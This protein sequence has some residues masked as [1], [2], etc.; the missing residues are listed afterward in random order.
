VAV[1]VQHPHIQDNIYRDIDILFNISAVLSLISQSLAFP[2]TK[3]NLKKALIDQLDFRIEERNLGRFNEFF[4]LHHN[5]HFPKV[6][7]EVTS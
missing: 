4:H 7:K 3:D 2:V 6:K 5:V 1:K